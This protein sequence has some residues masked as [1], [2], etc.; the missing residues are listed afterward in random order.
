M[1]VTCHIVDYHDQQQA[2]A[3]VELLNIYALDPMGGAKP[4]SEDVKYN[5]ASELA[6]LN[7]AFSIIAYVNK[8]PAGLANCF[9]GFSTFKSKPLINIH[10]LVVAPEF[11]GQK[12]ATLLLQKVEDIAKEKGC[13]KVTL[14][15]LNNNKIAKKAYA[16]FG[17]LGSSPEEKSDQMLFWEKPLT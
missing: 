14:E 17:F 6:K 1:T 15:V 3:L 7:Y 4:L 5:L 13:C 11:R 12:I 8:K 16:K 9:E 2:N 10:D